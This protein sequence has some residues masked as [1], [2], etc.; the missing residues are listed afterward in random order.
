MTKMKRYL[1]ENV[2][3]ATIKRL[4]YIFSK[5]D[6]VIVAFSGGKDSGVLLELVY[7]YYKASSSNVK[8]SVYH[9][10]YEGDTSR[11]YNM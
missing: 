1:K 11:L 8:V 2:Y 7:Q 9:L 10:D 3:Q 6:H 4:E 5:F